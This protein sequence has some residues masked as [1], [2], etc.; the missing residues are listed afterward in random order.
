MDKRAVCADAQALI[1]TSGSDGE[2]F[3][4]DSGVK[5]QSKTPDYSSAPL[6]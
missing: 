1:A 6:H 5:W 2:V 3:S 4:G